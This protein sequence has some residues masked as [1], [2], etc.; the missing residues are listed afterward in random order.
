MKLI[1]IVHTCSYYLCMA[2]G[3]ITGVG[4]GYSK[5]PFLHKNKS[6]KLYVRIP[7]LLM[8]LHNA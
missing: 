5:L 7:G 6:S 3:A 1:I 8:F 2:C 4:V